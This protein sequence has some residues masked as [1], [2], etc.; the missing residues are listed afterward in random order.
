MEVGQP[1]MNVQKLI[2]TV[3][4]IVAGAKGP[5]KMDRGEASFISSSQVQLYCLPLRIQSRE[6]KELSMLVISLMEGK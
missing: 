2:D 1:Q 3:M 4:A 5:L 6:G